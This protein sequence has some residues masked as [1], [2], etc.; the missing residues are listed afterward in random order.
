MKRSLA[1]SKPQSASSTSFAGKP[2]QEILYL[3]VWHRLFTASFLFSQS[4]ENHFYVWQRIANQALPTTTTRTFGA[5]VV[6]HRQ[7][8]SFSWTRHLVGGIIGFIW[9][10]DPSQL[11]CLFF[12]NWGSCTQLRVSSMQKLFPWTVISVFVCDWDNKFY[13]IHSHCFHSF[14]FQSLWGRIENFGQ[15]ARRNG[16]S[17][18][19][20]KR[21]SAAQ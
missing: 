10:L 11:S 21:L 2:V 9:S 20:P 14:M 15:F 16:R 4:P 3:S 1:N 12:F 17:T 13:L 18:E 6:R 5:S 19:V 8:S 7:W